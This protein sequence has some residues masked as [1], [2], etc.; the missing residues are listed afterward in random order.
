[1]HLTPNN[2][3]K[4]ITILILLIPTISKAQIEVSKYVSSDLFEVKPIILNSDK[5]ESEIE[6]PGSNFEKNLTEAIILM[7]SAEYDEAIYIFEEMI[8]FYPMAASLNYY[9]GITNA[10]KE[11]YEDSLL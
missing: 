3:F 4:I 7:H 11:Q 5:M 6:L 8:E 10:F 9:L 2:S 1:M